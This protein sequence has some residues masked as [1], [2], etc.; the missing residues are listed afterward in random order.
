VHGATGF[1][2]SGI[3][4]LFPRFQAGKRR[5]QRGVDVEDA[6]RKC[7][8]QRAFDEAQETGEANPGSRSPRWRFP[9][10]ARVRE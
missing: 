3:Q 1:G 8:Q 6:V 10:S 7:L 4:R 2:N 5:Q 9:Y